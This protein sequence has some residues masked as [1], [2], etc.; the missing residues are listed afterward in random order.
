MKNTR[1]KDCSWSLFQT[2]MAGR[3]PGRKRLQRMARIILFRGIEKGEYYLQVQKDASG[4]S[5][6]ET[7]PI[8]ADKA[9]TLI[10]DPGGSNALAIFAAANTE[11][12]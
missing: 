11:A 9:K 5:W 3:M 4:A 10:A 8:D 1:T 2:T 7:K 12:F 6:S